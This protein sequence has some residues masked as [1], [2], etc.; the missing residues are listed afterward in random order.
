LAVSGGVDL[1]KI[2]QA[3]QTLGDPLGIDAEK[4]AAVTL[5]VANDAMAGAI[6][7]VSL[8]RGFDPRDFAIFAFG[9]A[10]PLH[11]AALA[12]ELGVPRMIV[13][14]MPG[15]TCALGCILLRPLFGLWMPSPRRISKPSLQSTNSKQ[16]PG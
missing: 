7:L 15:I 10:G 13:P 12:R 8:Q 4:A 11:G 16:E 9:G 2:R 1:S 6:R 5:Q 14:Y 3:F